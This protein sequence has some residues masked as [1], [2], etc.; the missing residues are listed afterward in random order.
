MKSEC[1]PITFIL[2]SPCSIPIGHDADT[3]APNLHI[4]FR[5]L[6]QD[7]SSENHDPNSCENIKVVLA[8]AFVKGKG[9]LAR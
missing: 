1:T 2:E 9:L 8:E 7:L 4:S 3:G 5:I 6:R